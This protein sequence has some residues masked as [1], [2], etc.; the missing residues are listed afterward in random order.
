MPTKEKDKPI[1]HK[2]VVSI[3]GV[4]F[5]RMIDEKDFRINTSG[6]KTNNEFPQIDLEKGTPGT[7]RNLAEYEDDR[8]LKEQTLGLMLEEEKFT[9]P[10]ENNYNMDLKVGLPSFRLF[11]TKPKI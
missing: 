9:P 6:S 4:K 1:S 10:I 2:E 5:K 11:Y 7:N 8:V 3:K